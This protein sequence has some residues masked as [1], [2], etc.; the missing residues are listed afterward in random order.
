MTRGLKIAAIS[1]NILSLGFFTTDGVLLG[2]I[3]KS[4]TTVSS[5]VVFGMVM[6]ALVGTACQWASISMFR[7][8]R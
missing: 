7:H 2:A 3:L 5:F 8:A 6:V 4:D 1:A